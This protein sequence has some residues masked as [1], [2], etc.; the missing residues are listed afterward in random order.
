M[1]GAKRCTCT[2]HATLSFDHEAPIPCGTPVSACTLA[3]L[4]TPPPICCLALWACDVPPLHPHSFLI[5]WSRGCSLSAFQSPRFPPIPTLHGGQPTSPSI[6][7]PHPHAHETQIRLISSTTI[8]RAHP[9][10]P[11]LPIPTFLSGATPAILLTS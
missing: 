6:P 11:H 1:K 5:V 4:L 2:V 10:T 8:A 9:S 3:R 7:F